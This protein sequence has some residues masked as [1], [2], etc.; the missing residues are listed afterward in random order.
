MKTN[1]KTGPAGNMFKC[2]ANGLRELAKAEVLRVSQVVS[3]GPNY[4]TTEYIEPVDPSHKFFRKFGRE[5]ARM[6]RYKSEE[7][8][9]FDDN[10]IG[11]TPQLNIATGSQKYNWTHFFFEKR[12]LPQYRLLESNEFLTPALINGFR[13]ME[14]SLLKILD[15]VEEEGASILHGD[16][17]SGNFICTYNDSPVFIDPAVYYGHRETDLAITKL[18]GYFHQDFYTSYHKEYPLADGWQQR[19]KV[20]Q[21]YHLMNHINLFGPSYISETEHLLSSLG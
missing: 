5:L 2:E 14:S 8:G 19:F 21:L 12:L 1:T 18:F 6:H 10:F 9:F 20:Y 15:G 7:Y 11:Y 16:L 3:Y 4:I 17:W 13:R